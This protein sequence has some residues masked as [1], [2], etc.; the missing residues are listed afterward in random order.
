MKKGKSTLRKGTAL[1]NQ[2]TPA[3][4]EPI[5]IQRGNH[6]RNRGGGV[7]SCGKKGGRLRIGAENAQQLVENA[8]SSAVKFSFEWEV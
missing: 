5:Q 6:C 1:P 3:Y 8:G 4:L 7:Y 2:E